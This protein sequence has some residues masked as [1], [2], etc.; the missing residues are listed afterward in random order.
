MPDGYPFTVLNNTAAAPLPSSAQHQLLR[1]VQISEIDCSAVVVARS[2]DGFEWDGV[3]PTPVELDCAGLASNG[4]PA[5]TVDTTGTAFGAFR[6]DSLEQAA[7]DVAN[8]DGIAITKLLQQGTFG[9]TTMERARLKSFLGTGAFPTFTTSSGGG[10][11]NVGTSAGGTGTSV[12]NTGGSKGDQKGKTVGEAARAW[13]LEQLAEDPSYHRVH[14]R[15]RTNA[16]VDALKYGP[17]YSGGLFNRCQVGSRWQ[18]FTF[19]ERDFEKTLVVASAVGHFQLLVNGV[20]RSEVVQ[21]GNLTW[22][23]AYPAGPVQEFTL[24]SGEERVDA[25]LYIMDGAGVTCN[26]RTYIDTD[27]PEWRTYNTAIQ[28]LGTPD[29]TTTQVFDA[30][31]VVST[32]VAT[33]NTDSYYLRSIKQASSFASNCSNEVGRNGRSFVGF[34]RDVPDGTGGTAIEVTYLSYD[35]RLKLIDNTPEAPADPSTYADGL[36]CPAAPLSFL[37][38]GACTRRASDTCAPLKFADGTLIT[39][40]S[41]T[42]RAWYTTSQQYVY[43]VTGLRLTEAHITSTHPCKT[44]VRSRWI[45]LPGACDSNAGLDVFGATGETI[46]SALA[47]A[48]ASGADPSTADI[49]DLGLAQY[50]ATYASQGAACDIA[51]IADQSTGDVAGAQVEVEGHCWRHHH[52]NERDVYDFTRWTIAHPGNPDFF[53]RTNGGNP[54]KQFAEDESANDGVVLQYPW[55][56][57]M[58]RWGTYVNHWARYFIFIG[59]LG[60]V[61]DFVTLPISLQT[62]GMATY[63]GASTVH[64]S[65]IGV[66]ACG[67][68][69]EVANDPSLGNTYT[70][71]WQNKRQG[72]DYQHQHWEN[73]KSYVW[74][75]VVLT[76]KDQLRQRIAWALSQIFVLGQP[77]VTFHNQ[78]EVWNHYYDIFVHNAFGNYK[79][80][81]KEVS[82]H[83]AMGTYLTYDGNKAFASGGNF[84]DENYVSTSCA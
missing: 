11:R 51:Y 50:T 23:S 53:L 17:A 64:G 82:S 58:S 38:R 13:V 24:C 42:L 5:C 37:N 15:R 70:T 28:F 43:A 12:T 49:R 68:R 61:L 40:N 34:A 39:L 20:V 62:A 33:T 31:D 71:F 65:S 66:E 27:A 41:D 26:W 63:A 46:K 6:V 9:P 67:S 21:F 59:K 30:D 81:M 25:R 80:V 78:Q 45:R 76:S 52:E 1:L 83:A 56:H 84:P 57:P 54:I 7:S 79:D 60:Q 77:G 55:H 14:V 44:G 3:Q 75:N 19:D 69:G 8:G 22:S 4:V 72:V 74:Q 10:R 36:T 47:A 48:A 2:Y 32:Q 29:V 16:R 18:R 35:P 73:G